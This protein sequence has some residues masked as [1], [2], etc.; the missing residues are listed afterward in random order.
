[1][2]IMKTVLRFGIDHG[3]SSTLG[4]TDF[5]EPFPRRY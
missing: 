4:L 2:F 1:M 3:H 5:D